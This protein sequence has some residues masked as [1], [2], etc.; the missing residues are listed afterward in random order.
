[1]ACDL[2][3]INLRQRCK[4]AVRL[5]ASAELPLFETFYFGWQQAA[6]YLF[7]ITITASHHRAEYFD[8]SWAS[9]VCN[10]FEKIST[11]RCLF[12]S[13]RSASKL[14]NSEGSKAARKKAAYSLAKVTASPVCSYCAS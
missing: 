9:T 2:N 14:T 7:A 8:G 13:S 11:M 5:L 3:L 12:R 6:N 10:C 1:V 4:S